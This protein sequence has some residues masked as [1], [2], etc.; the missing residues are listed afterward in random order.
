MEEPQPSTSEGAQP[1]TSSSRKKLKGKDLSLL[2]ATQSGKC[3]VPKDLLYFRERARLAKTKTTARKSTWKHP[4]DR[5]ASNLPQKNL[6]KENARKNAAKAALAAQ[7]N[8]SSP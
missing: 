6:S 3:M 5:L 1:S 8:L 2:M 4:R 7:K